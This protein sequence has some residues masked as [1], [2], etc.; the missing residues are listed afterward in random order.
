MCPMV[1]CLF[2]VI[3]QTV[4]ASRIA[5]HMEHQLMVVAPIPILIQQIFWGDTKKHLCIMHNMIYIFCVCVFWDKVLIK[6]KQTRHIPSNC[7]QNDQGSN[8]HLALDNCYLKI[9]RWGL[10]SH[11]ETITRNFQTISKVLLLF[12]YTALWGDNGFA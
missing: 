7:R 1:R 11:K 9:V 6:R 12:R 2:S 5:L 3:H 4:G 10:K 8:R